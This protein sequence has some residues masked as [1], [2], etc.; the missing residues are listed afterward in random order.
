MSEAVPARSFAPAFSQLY[1]RAPEVAAQAPGRVNIIGEHTD[2]N[3]GFV[4]PTPI[5]HRTLVELAKRD[6]RIVRVWSANVGQDRPAEYVLGEEA[7]GRGWID[8]VEGITAVLRREGMRLRGFDA[9]IASDVP[10]GAGLASSA[11]L[12]IALLRGL[13]EALGLPLDDLRMAVLGQRA[14]N[15]F[16]GARVGIMD[17]MVCS[18]GAEGTALLIDTRNLET[19]QIRLPPS[20]EL[21]VIDSAVR[22]SHAFGEYGTRRKEC[23]EAAR[24]LGVEHLRDVQDSVPPPWERLPD[25]LNRRVRHVVAENVRVLHAVEALR[26][27]DLTA[28]GAL[29]LESHRSLRDDYEVSIPELDEIV[30][31]ARGEPAIFGARMTGGGFGGSVVLIGVRGETRAAA[32]RIARSYGERTGR[33]A[34]VLLPLG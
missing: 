20:G 27:E 4:L 12:E 33:A 22:H 9:R 1:G 14:E 17:Q 32:R 10:L 3:G 21:G 31:L 25:P 15:D 29:L 2:Y 30:E 13:R 19:G 24:L 28:L 16:V 23:E 6:D 7:A 18:L 34:R 11:A 5:P 8:Y 26:R